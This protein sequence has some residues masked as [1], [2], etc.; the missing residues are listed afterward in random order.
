[1]LDILPKSKTLPSRSTTASLIPNNVI[2]QFRTE[3]E[4]HGLRPKEIVADGGLHRCPVEDKPGTK[5]GAY[6]LHIDHPASGWWKNWRTGEEDTWSANG[7]TPLSKVERDQLTRRIE[8]DKRQR[9]QEQTRRHAEAAGQAA[10]LLKQAKDCGAHPYLETKGVKPCPLLKVD[11]ESKL[12]V[13]LLGP[14][15][16]TQSLQTIT[17]GGAKRFLP[18][19]KTSCGYFPIG[20]DKTGPLLICEGLAT[21]L[22]LY[23]ATGHTVLVAF[24]AGNLK[25]VAQM[26]RARYPDR[27]I[28]ICGDDDRQT[29]GNPGRS[30]A[31]I[32]ALA[33]GAKLALPFFQS[34]QAG[35]DFNDL[36][37]DE[38]KDVVKSQVDAAENPMA[39]QQAIKDDWPFEVNQEGVFK[40]VEK[41]NKFSGETEVDWLRVCSPLEVLA[42][43][44]NADGK[45]WGRL[46][47]IFTREDRINEWAMPMELLAGDGS[48][49]RAE[50]L[51]LGLDISPGN[52]P[53]HAL[54]EYISTA[55]PGVRAT[56]VDR[57]GW[58]GPVFVLPDRTI[59]CGME[60]RILFQVGR[61]Q[62]HQFRTSGTFEEWQQ[63][64]SLAEG[65]SRL[66][67]AISAA[68]AAPLLFL[69]GAES[70][71]FH[72]R[73]GSSTGKTTT[74]LVAGS[75]W[76]GGG[77]N[78]YCRNWR[79]TGNGLEAVAALHC[80]SLLCLDEMGQV[81]GR[82]AGA[83]AYMLANGQGKTR[84]RRDGSG[85]LPVQWRVIFLSTGEISLADK[86]NE[87]GNRAKAGQEV[88][89]IDIPADAGAGMG[90]IEELHGHAGPGVLA[91]KLRMKASTV[92]G[93]AAPAFLNQ[94]T[95]KPEGLTNLVRSA[96]QQF[97]D[98]YC[99]TDADGQVKRV[100]DRFG[101][102]AAA[103]V[104][105]T[106]IQMVPWS[107]D[108]AERS[109]ARCFN[110]WL[111]QRGGAGAQEVQAGL[112]QVRSFIQA[113]GGSRFQ[114][115][116]PVS[117]EK[118]I[119]RAGFVRSGEEGKE[120]LI[121]PR[122]FKN[123]VC[124]GQDS[125]A[126]ARELAE[127]G[128][129]VVGGGDSRL[130][131]VVRP[132][133]IKKTRM[134]VVMESILTGEACSD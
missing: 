104:L 46:L 19:G 17:P 49:Y 16:Q 13:P 25:P 50:L 80:D 75:V 125:K 79:S 30:K 120:Y 93:T 115:W 129:L 23:E 71:G 100:A 32:A 10:V 38:G 81:D 8:A 67:F 130:T 44:R 43:T 97:I 74:L 126:V 94:I 27:T 122:T 3:I 26:A 110:D 65:N 12:L 113:H 88:R 117:D 78:G 132:P 83:I 72:F 39:T 37:Q 53:R 9:T 121:F 22:S 99:P 69:A 124:K 4:S 82:E 63:I 33:V 66:V 18:G 47:A 102:V 48:G 89:L 45:D 29:E 60:E 7:H 21:G 109:A 56:C 6:I 62:D 112:E 55:T 128:F 64:T 54:H 76:G 68:F 103:G 108:E 116:E 95:A 101:L 91:D 20:N 61:P 119:N 14:D 2:A 77:I 90:I 114:R 31:T 15:T 70:G 98:E 85:R 131:M 106:A 87:S 84:A 57:L 36:H 59:G 123:E 134:Y 41:K 73:G 111:D 105:A 92:Y 107:G 86:M 11:T 42:E 52:P 34:S 5:D 96:K 118:I 24:N 51:S 1:M 58:H 127:R 35:T 40:R 28:V 133:G